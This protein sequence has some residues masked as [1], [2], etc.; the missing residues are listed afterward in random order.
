M[1]FVYRIVLFICV[2]TF[3]FFSIR[4]LNIINMQKLVTNVG[5]IPWLY[6]TI[7]LIFGITSA[8][9][10]QSEWNNWNNLEDSVKEE[11]R[12]IRRLLQF[13]KH[14]PQITGE[15]I[16]KSVKLYLHAVIECWN[17][18][19]R[20]QQAED[21]IQNLQEEMYSVFERPGN[22]SQIGFSIVTK[23][24]THRDNRVHYSS[25][26]L[27]RTLKILIAFSTFLLI[28]ISL[29]I[30]VND[31]TYDYILT[32]S[33]AVLGYLI[34]EVINDLSNP[35]NPGSWH[36]TSADYKKLLEEIK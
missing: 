24:L 34:W 11:T 29:F 8:F 7:G 3:L 6:S 33:I 14:L 36:I 35:L 20:S 19:G 18:N 16:N 12:S 10:I 30:G 32:L 26:S 21:A 15:K 23:I 5:G 2:F 25:R 1:G 31:I 4:I 22:V 27:P 9:I 13:N 17:E 28:F